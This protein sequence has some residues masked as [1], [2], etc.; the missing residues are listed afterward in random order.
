M[1]QKVATV[2]GV[3]T[4][5]IRHDN[6]RPGKHGTAVFSGIKNQ[7]GICSR[8]SWKLAVS[9]PGAQ[10]CR[11]YAGVSTAGFAMSAV[12]TILTTGAN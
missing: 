2:A 5:K 3:P 7:I 10:Y 9:H 11:L 6:G 8:L 1:S 12:L 4:T